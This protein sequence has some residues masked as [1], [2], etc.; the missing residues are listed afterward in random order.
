MIP[1]LRRFAIRTWLEVVTRLW[2]GHRLGNKTEFMRPRKGPGLSVLELPQNLTNHAVM[3]RLGGSLGGPPNGNNMNFS[4]FLGSKAKSCY[5]I[6]QVAC[7]HSCLFGHTVNSLRFC[8][9]PF[10]NPRGSALD[11]WACYQ[12]L[13]WDAAGPSS[14]PPQLFLFVSIRVPK[15]YTLPCEVLS[16]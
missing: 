2:L 10:D 6:V 14:T 16:L 12:P 9:G 1:I 13:Q 11:P 4:T 5:G 3:A 8:S 7:M 15:V